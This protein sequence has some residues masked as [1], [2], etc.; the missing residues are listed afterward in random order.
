MTQLN[1]SSEVVDLARDLFESM[2]PRRWGA[3]TDQRYWLARARILHKAGWRK[4][5]GE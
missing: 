2:G 5:P 4:T 1:D 3:C